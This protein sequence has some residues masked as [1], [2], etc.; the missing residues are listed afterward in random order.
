MNKDER[1]EAGDRYKIEG[2]EYS[3]FNEQFILFL[4]NIPHCFDALYQCDQSSYMEEAARNS[5]YWLEFTDDYTLMIEYLFSDEQNNFE[6]LDSFYEYKC[7]DLNLAELE[8]QMVKFYF[9]YQWWG[10]IYHKTV[11]N[12]LL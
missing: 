7:L 10:F 8:D 3:Y 2:D 6:Y 4:G 1:I 11:L 5:E 9:D 12:G